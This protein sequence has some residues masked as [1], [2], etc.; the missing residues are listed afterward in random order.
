[1]G[2]AMSDCVARCM[3]M[4]SCADAKETEKY[5][6]AVV[7]MDEE[8]FP[9]GSS[10]VLTPLEMKSV[11][12]KA[13]QDVLFSTEPVPSEMRRSLKA[14]RKQKDILEAS[15]APKKSR[16]SVGKMVPSMKVI[17]LK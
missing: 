10:S 4:Y 17:E 15:P 14:K 6:A 3:C 5:H 16:R 7:P 2:L 8:D 11:Q 13:K 9:R 1:M 12:E